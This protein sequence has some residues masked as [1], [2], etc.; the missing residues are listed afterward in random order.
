[1]PHVFARSAEAI[2]TSSA[3]ST[4]ATGTSS[5]AGAMILS[6]LDD[7]TLLRL[8]A[9]LG[10]EIVRRQLSPERT[11]SPRLPK[12]LWVHVLDFA[13]RCSP[14][15]LE[16][17]RLVNVDFRDAI[18]DAASAP[19]ALEEAYGISWLRRRW[20]RR[21]VLPRH[22]PAL[23]RLADQKLPA[24]LREYFA[25]ENEEKLSERLANDCAKYGCR[26]SAAIEA[27]ATLALDTPSTKDYLAT[28]LTNALVSE[29]SLCGGHGETRCF[30]GND[31]IYLVCRSCRMEEAA[32][33]R[34]MNEAA[35]Q[36]YD[37]RSCFL[38]ARV[39]IWRRQAIVALGIL[40]ASA[41]SAWPL[42]VWLFR[43][44]FT[45]KS[46]AV[47]SGVQEACVDAIIRIGAAV[48]S[49]VLDGHLDYLEAFLAHCQ[50]PRLREDAERILSAFGRP[51]SL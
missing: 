49:S 44:G 25:C 20:A 27:L 32:R 39:Q 11:F 34:V 23:W 9:R 6:R 14:V 3:G 33:R 12:V 30:Y 21:A 16:P 15:L 31:F 28:M 26:R 1:M 5:A 47:N 10:F 17:L 7:A 48:P 35:R 45:C 18:L 42:L 22:A 51:V 29:C 38:E 2:D 50:R 41:L 13:Y 36:K 37:E 40:G 43:N 19:A 46:I 8:H 24:R 4:E